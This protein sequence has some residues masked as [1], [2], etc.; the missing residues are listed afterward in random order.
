MQLVSPV[1]TAKQ[2]VMA[3]GAQFGA[4]IANHANSTSPSSATLANAT[5]GY[6]TLGGRWQFA[7][8]GGAA[9][10]YALFAYAVPATH[11]L[12]IS[13]VDIYTINTGAAV[14]TS[15]HIF[16]WS[17]GINGTAIDLGTTDSGATYATRRIT[18]GMQGLLSGAAIGAAAEPIKAKFDQPLAVEPSRY[19]HIIL[20][21]PVATATGSQVIRGNC[22]VRGWFERVGEITAGL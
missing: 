16:D 10:D 20:Q 1:M 21:M 11:R 14:A 4:Q 7:A 15:A 18:L 9:T 13:G 12:W 19:V 6:A 22:N 8:V 3:P 5:A 17:L 2:S